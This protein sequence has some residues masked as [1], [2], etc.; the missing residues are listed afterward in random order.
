MRT[1]RKMF[2][3]ERLDV[4][5]KAMQYSNELVDIAESLSNKYQFTF[6]NH[7]I[8]LAISIPNNIAE[9]SGR[10]SIKESSNFYNISKGSVYE[11]INLLILLNNRKLINVQAL[12]SKYIQAEE[13]CKMLSGLIKVNK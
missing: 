11:S 5:H 1:E 3:F 12:D 13:I 7:L 4:W 8:Q 10:R 9:G 2:R 6:S